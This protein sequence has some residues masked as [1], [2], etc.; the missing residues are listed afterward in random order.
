[1]FRILPALVCWLALAAAP[2]S[3]LSDEKAVE[4][5]TAVDERA[6]K[7]SSF[8]SEFHLIR[9]DPAFLELFFP[10][11]QFRSNLSVDGI[12]NFDSPNR[13]YNL[14]LR[15]EG[16]D[17]QHLVARGTSVV[18]IGQERIPNLMKDPNPIAVPGASPSPSP[19]PTPSPEA[20]AS[21]GASP[22]PSPSPSPVAYE[23]L[24]PSS[25]E[26]VQF[27]PLLFMWPFVL[28]SDAVSQY[29][30]VSEDE[31]VYGR[32]CYLIEVRNSAA[33]D[34]V[35]LWVDPKGEQITQVE[36]VR[37]D[38]Q[39]VLAT[40]MGFHPPDKETGYAIYN[41]VEVSV[42][43]KSVYM[44][45]LTTPEINP[46]RILVT[47]GDETVPVN[48]SNRRGELN[49]FIGELPPIISGALLFLV[50]VLGI[51]LAV[52]GYRYYR[53][54]RSRQE[55]TDELVLIDEEDGRFGELLERLG[56]SWIP[57]NPEVL[58]QERMLLG[59]GATAD[60]TRK[61]RGVVVAPESFAE[62]K[63]YFFL[64]KAYVEEGGR[65][66]VMYH[67]PKTAATMP[68][69][70]SFI[71]LMPGDTA[72]GYHC[73]SGVFETVPDDEVE[74]LCGALAAKE[75]YT[76][77]NERPVSHEIV[78]ARNKSTGVKGTVLGVVRQGK[79]EYILCQLRFDPKLTASSAPIRRL[80]G[81]LIHL[82]QARS[83]K[84][85]QEQTATVS[86]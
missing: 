51:G 80:L 21:P 85:A 67:T 23:D 41:R 30:L 79:G 33:K 25:H 24:G 77:V 52:L 76:Q 49:T 13:Q 44:A 62:V 43:G 69:T 47:K 58:T 4:A 15:T 3:A 16:I 29:H 64:L 1:M 37:A 60:T 53:F 31:V 7:V 35:R 70:S 75:L 72:T 78:V 27:H 54:A 2:A 12:L 48:T 57:F 22:S 73:R 8:Q 68:F 11:S 59:K 32:K 14:Y 56:Y 5:M 46:N 17:Y 55:F 18:W 71:P 34:Q 74:R 6:L 28:Q 83:A 65:V 66:L 50:S 84:R 42:D 19:S 40:Y 9:Q 63:G 10:E 81:D 86:G 82:L 61:P 26:P 39:K 38:G 45:E 20:S 36:I